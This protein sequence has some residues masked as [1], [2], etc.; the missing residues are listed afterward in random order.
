MS[1][2]ASPS[3]PPTWARETP[4]SNHVVALC[5]ALLVVLASILI[6]PSREGATLFGVALPP[7]CALKTL[8]GLDCP[9]CGLTRSFGFMGEGSPLQA[10]KMHLFG[11]AL[12]IFVAAQIP[13]RLMILGRRLYPW[14]APA[15]DVSE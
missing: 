1:A 10:L 5:A 7:M 4:T 13:Y 8:T 2:A 12:W 14:N 11:P 9:G 6:D 3:P 15:A